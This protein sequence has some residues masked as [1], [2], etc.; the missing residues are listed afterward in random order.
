MLSNILDEIDIGMCLSVWEDNGP[1]VVM[2]FLNNHVPVVG[3]KL[4]GIPDFVH[5]GINGYLFNPFDYREID[6]IVCVLNTMT[7]QDLNK[8]KSNICR[9]TTTKEH[10]GEIDKIYNSIKMNK[11]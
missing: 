11:Q 9:T 6:R 8:L 5:D 3:T 4:G 10:C 2:E 1:Q 7:R